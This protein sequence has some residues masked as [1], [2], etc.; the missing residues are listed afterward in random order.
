MKKTNRVLAVIFAVLITLVVIF[1]VSFISDNAHHDCLGENCPI[2]EQ[3]QIAENII[4]KISTVMLVVVV[5]L[6]L[7]LLAHFC[8]R[9]NRVFTVTKSPILLKVKLLN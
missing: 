7:C 6:F 2:C 1:S 9:E 4:N 8:H 3:M 5:G